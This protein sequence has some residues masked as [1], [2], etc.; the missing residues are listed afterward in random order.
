MAPQP[1]LISRQNLS[2]PSQTDRSG[3]TRG[4]SRLTV[5]PGLD[6][7]LAQQLDRRQPLHFIGVGGIGMS[8]IAGILADRG[9]QVSGSDP[10]DNAV[11]QD[12]RSRGVRVF[13]EQSATTIA[14]IRS[15]TS[16]QPLVVVSSAVPPTNP[17]LQ[18]ARRA[19]LE[20]AHRSD[21]LAALIASQ[22]DQAQFMV[23]SHRRPMI[24]AATRTIGVTQARGAHTQVVGLPPTA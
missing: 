1:G 7:P 22:A 23:V 4:A 6:T 9:Y 5:S 8:A 10:R 15:G 17:E 16:T 13:R 18:E 20:I 3:Q 12:L 24:A 2:K 11:L 21:V 14:A 19:G